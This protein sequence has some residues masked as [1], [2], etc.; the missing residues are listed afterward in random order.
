MACQHHLVNTHLSTTLIILGE[1][2]GGWCRWPGSPHG[3]S[4]LWHAVQP[5]GGSNSKLPLINKPNVP[6]NL[7]MFLCKHPESLSFN[8]I[9]KSE[10]SALTVTTVELIVSHFIKKQSRKLL[11]A[12]S[13]NVSTKDSLDLVLVMEEQ[14]GREISQTMQHI[15]LH[16]GQ[17]KENH[18]CRWFKHDSF[19]NETHI[20]CP[21]GNGNVWLD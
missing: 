14:S 9:K 17:E 19:I 7:I 2:G 20:V 3:P 10:I 16:H 21:S 1:G 12:Y 15:Q 5:R 18:A 8:Y 6:K 4:S 13:P 11:L